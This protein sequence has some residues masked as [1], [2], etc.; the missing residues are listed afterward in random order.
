MNNIKLPVRYTLFAIKDNEVKENDKKIAYIIGKCYVLEVN[1]KYD[2]QGNAYSSY[3]I[4][5]CD[6]SKLA[7]KGDEINDN[8]VEYV[9]YLYYDYDEAKQKRIELNKKLFDK[10]SKTYEEK[11]IEKLKIKIEKMVNSM[12][13]LK[14][15][16][17]KSIEITDEKSLILK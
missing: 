10:I 11:E 3:T 17:E 12:Q 15:V 6:N 4:I 5:S 14:K 7:F 13:K 1:I 2:L 9:K 8:Y 16:K